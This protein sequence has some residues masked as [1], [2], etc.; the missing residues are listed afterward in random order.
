MVRRRATRVGAS[1]AGS[2]RSD[3]MPEHRDD[4]GLVQED[5]MAGAIADALDH[6][7][8]VVGEPPGGVASGPAAAILE[9]LRQVP[10]VEARPGLDS[11][12]EQRIDQAIVEVEAARVDRASG[13]RA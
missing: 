8:R 6:L 5:E 2:V 11:G 1:H 7:R 12:F 4:A 10:M 3:Q 9:S 13:L